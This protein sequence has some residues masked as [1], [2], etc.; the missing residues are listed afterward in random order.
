MATVAGKHMFIVE[1]YDDYF[2]QMTAIF[3][4]GNIQLIAEYA[5]AIAELQEEKMRKQEDDSGAW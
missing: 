5:E 4:P 1:V 2:Q 3:V